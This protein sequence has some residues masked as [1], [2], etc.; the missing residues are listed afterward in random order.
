MRT[1]RKEK[2]NM[3]AATFTDL[4]TFLLETL[5]TDPKIGVA[6]TIEAKN[7]DAPLKVKCLRCEFMF[8]GSIENRICQTCRN[9]NKELA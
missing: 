4:R 1:T 9:Y 2:R 8:H 6:P 5:M 3:N 7:S